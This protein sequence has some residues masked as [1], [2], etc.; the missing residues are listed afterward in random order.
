[1][2]IRI[3]QVA[4]KFGQYEENGTEILKE[5][6]RPHSLWKTGPKTINSFEI[7]VSN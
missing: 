5:K 4:E 2:I 3:S 7:L 6:Q 1:M